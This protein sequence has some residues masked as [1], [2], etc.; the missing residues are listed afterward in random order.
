M[1]EKIKS[2]ELLGILY[3]IIDAEFTTVHCCE[4][5]ADHI[6]N[7][8][9]KE[10]FHS[11]IKTANEN[12]EKLKFY[13]S[14][15][16]LN[17]YEAQR[18]CK[19]CRISPESFSLIGAINLQLEIINAAVNSYKKLLDVLSEK[20]V[21]HTIKE[22][23]RTKLNEKNFLK[24]EKQFLENKATEQGIFS[25]YCIPDVATKLWR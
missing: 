15:L 19:F 23:I 24:K 10:K 20:E 8:K 3:N 17:E 4:H 25:S 1:T 2:E 22:I 16:G 14:K 18:H 11:F 6:K 7:G 21:K 9:I 5:L 13:F 12:R